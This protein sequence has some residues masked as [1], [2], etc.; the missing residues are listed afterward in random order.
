MATSSAA[1]RV[2]ELLPPPA[3]PPAPTVLRVALAATPADEAAEEV[4]PPLKP[5]DMAAGEPEDE[6]TGCADLSTATT[7]TYPATIVVPA[8]PRSMASG[9]VASVAITVGQ[10]ADVV[11][12]P[13]SALVGVQSGTGQVQ[14]LTGSGT[15]TRAVTVG[16]VGSGFAQVMTGLAVGDRVVLA[17][18][19]AALPS[20]QSNGLRGLGSGGFAGR[21]GGTGGVAAGGRPGR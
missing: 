4:A 1:T 17:D 6:P 13:V 19:N 9:S 15:T 18:V 12:V 16:A 5:A 11:R 8:P 3:A 20:T 14:V 2:A 10:A 7:P 21:G